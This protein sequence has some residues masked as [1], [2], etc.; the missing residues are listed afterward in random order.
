[1]LLI[2][3][4]E[5]SASLNFV[6]EGNASLTT[7]SWPYPRWVFVPGLPA[8]HKQTRATTLRAFPAPMAAFPGFAYTRALNSLGVLI[9][10]PE[11]LRSLVPGMH[12]S[13][14]W[15]VLEK[16]TQASNAR[17]PLRL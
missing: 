17:G 3:M 10:P 6:P 11:A 1:M 5:S 4:T 2:L 14:C 16:N 9:P 8:A 13:V 15:G 7:W 12:A